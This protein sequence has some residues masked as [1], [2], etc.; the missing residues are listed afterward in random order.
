MSAKIEAIRGRA[1]MTR[2]DQEAAD[3]NDRLGVNEYR[4]GQ[5]GTICATPKWLGNAERKEDECDA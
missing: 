1:E 5:P 4:P 2:V 3:T